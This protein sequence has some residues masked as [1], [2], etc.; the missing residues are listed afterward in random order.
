[1]VRAGRSRGRAFTLVELLV[2]V[3][4]VSVLV[5]LLMPVLGRARRQANGLVCLSNVRQFGL[6]YQRE[7]A[8][9][10][11]RAPTVTGGSLYTLMSKMRPGEEQPVPLCPEASELGTRRWNRGQYDALLGSAHAA[12]GEQII[13]PTLKPV[14]TPWPGTHGCSY[15]VNRCSPSCTAR[16]TAT[17]STK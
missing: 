15:A 3:G 8:E 14:G 9:N 5:A 2:V 11:N 6:A 17:T 1:M 10:K 7:V 16:W 4:I 12:W 13:D